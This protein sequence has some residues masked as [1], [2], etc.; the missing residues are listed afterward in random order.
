[1][2][3]RNGPARASLEVEKKFGG[4]EIILNQSLVPKRLQRI[5]RKP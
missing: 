4:S 1:M 3:P 2:Q 5:W